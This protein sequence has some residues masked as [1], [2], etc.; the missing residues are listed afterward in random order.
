MKKIKLDLEDDEHDVVEKITC[1]DK[2]DDGEIKG[3]PQLK[4]SGGFEIMYC[5]S[6]CKE[7]KP[8]NCSWTAKDLKGNVGSQS[9]LYLRPIQKNLCTVSILP[10]N[11]SQVKEKCI[12]CNKQIL[13]KDQR[14]HVFMFSYIFLF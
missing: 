13:M 5:V 2:G 4:E 6:G 14:H 10:E 1:G 9:K 11:K 8:L 3:F 7:L 12:I